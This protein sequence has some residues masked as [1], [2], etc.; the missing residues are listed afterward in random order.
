MLA[1]QAR[2]TVVDVA[3][4]LRAAKRDG[5]HEPLRRSDWSRSGAQVPA[6]GPGPATAAA[7]REAGDALA[8]CYLELAP[9]HRRVIG[10]RQFEGLSAREA[11]SRMGR[12]ETAVHSL[13]R[14]ALGAWQE[15]LHGKS[16]FARRERSVRAPGQPM[17]EPTE[18]RDELEDRLDGLVA[19]YS[20]Q[21]A[22]GK[23]PR[24]QAFLERVPPE[25][26][27][28]LERC[29]KM[30]EA[31]LASAPSAAAPLAAGLVLGRYRLVRELGRGG[32]ALVWLAQDTELRR[33][34]A[35]KILRPGLALES[36]HVDR[37]RRE[38]LA[39]A[40]L[41]HPNIVQIH[42]VGADKGFHYLA[43][44]Y[45]EGPSLARV[46]EAL[47]PDGRGRRWSAEELARAAGIPAL[48]GRG[49][50]LEQAIA[51]LLVP[52]AQALQAAHE[53]GIVH[54]DVKPSNILLRKDGT[55]VV[56]DFGL[57]KSD[58]DPALSMT[59]D[60]LGT[61]FYM[62]PEQAWLADVRVDHRTDIYSLGV[63][64]FEALAGS[65]PFE[66]QNPLEVFER[67]RSSLVPSLR[68]VEERAT[69]DAAAVVR[70]AMAREPAGRYADARELAEE[71]GALAQGLPTRACAA[72]GGALRQG[73]TSLRVY[74]SGMPFEYRS[75][76]TLLGLPLVHVINGPLLPGRPKRVARGWFA[77]SPEVAIGVVAC[78]QRAYGVLA[79]GGMACGVVFSFGGIAVG[80]LSSFGGIALAAL[81]WGGLSAGYISMGGISAGYGAIGGIAVGHYAMGGLPYGNHVIS[82]SKSD[83]TEE[84]WWAG[85]L[86]P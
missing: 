14:R 72:Q 26:R 43:M 54:R 34:V 86:P 29:L 49:R 51:A 46:L 12:S 15:S 53:R 13:Y 33:P 4:A 38:A 63:C 21:L 85:V 30:I 73:L 65:R 6:A 22:A 8:R 70:K 60:T 39:I 32:M 77:S 25:A 50:T 66:G 36:A 62:S 35:L 48:A 19:E 64:L 71:L 17:S 78:A 24:K 16:R 59:G 28:G 5:V 2:H 27:A 80:L 81:A 40:K 67:I 45:V 10:L 56:A 79:C 7:A 76:R 74:F 52:A 83:L 57:A 44:E 1:Q 41:A 23:G 37:F 69:R 11:A 55:P 75:P 20:D 3:R 68:S 42:D 84:Q 31:G 58:G 82:D 9:E 18:S 47:G 61:P